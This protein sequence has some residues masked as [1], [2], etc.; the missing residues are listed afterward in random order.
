VAC[1]PAVIWLPCR[2][3][4]CGEVRNLV[5]ALTAAAPAGCVLRNQDYLPGTR[6]LGE[7]VR[8]R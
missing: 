6:R 5:P 1:L 7:V 8:K 4:A 2:D 3:A